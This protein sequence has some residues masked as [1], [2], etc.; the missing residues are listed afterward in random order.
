M[1]YTII[2]LV[3]IIILMLYAGYMYLTN[4]NITTGVVSL[5]AP[6]DYAQTKWQKL[7]NPGST[8]Y[9]YEG[10]LF[11]N[12][13][14]ASGTIWTICGRKMNSG[15]SGVV[16]A[17]SS[18][19]FYKGASIDSMGLTG[20]PN[21][22][23]SLVNIINDFPIQK[24]VYFVVNVNG[25]LVEAYLNG[26]L[27]TTQVIPTGTATLTPSTRAELFLG[28]SSCDGY[29]T[30][31]KRIASV[32]TADQ[33]WANYLAGNGLATFTNWLAGYN[34]SLSI[35]NSVNDVKTYSLL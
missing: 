18:L 14:P 29:I 27:V 35:T 12:G 34:A 8:Q 32:L 22:L 30:K 7:D 5:K 33:A 6:G 26:K 1:N 19:A 11:M 20:A 9:H 2:A 10:W 3:F 4:T 24:W 17:G 21:E 15:A 16:L 28:S 25:Q 13:L 31:F 23:S